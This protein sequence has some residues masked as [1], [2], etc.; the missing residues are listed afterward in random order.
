MR[1]NE[2]ITMAD[3]MKRIPPA[4]RPIVAAVRSAAR[5]TARDADEVV[6]QSRR[7]ASPS[8]M[9]KLVRYRLDGADVAGIGTFSE[10]ATLFF[11]R[12]RELHDDAGLLAGSGKD[13][14]FVS[15]R[16]VG[17]AKRPAVRQLLDEA[18]AMAKARPPRP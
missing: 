9:W 18:F 15:L 8:S 17:D 12:G 6:Y 5:S 1:K 4:T 11:Y 16:T 7:P 3:H 13:S 14:R 2:A 10:H